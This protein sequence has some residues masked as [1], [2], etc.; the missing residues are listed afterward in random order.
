MDEIFEKRTGLCRGKGG[1]VHLFAPA[2]RFSC[3]GIVGSSLPVA[4]G[5]AYAARLEGTDALAVGVTGDGGTNTG[6]FH[7]T[8]NMAAIWRLPLVVLVENNQYAIS[9]PAT[10][11]IAGSGIAERAAAYGAWGMRV[12]GTDVEAVA[13]AF[14][15]A[16]DHARNG[17]GPALL[18]A[19]CFRFRGHYEG[20]TDHYRSD[21]HKERMLTQGDP[22]WITGRRL[23]DRGEA[24]DARLSEIDREVRA[25]IAAVLQ[26]AREAPEPGPDEAFTDVFA[27]T[28]A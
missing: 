3:T 6:Q 10:D 4:L 1:H 20:D 5:H 19:T 11:V 7:E 13:R 9:V 26:R 8:M 14:R 27:E 2:Q 15:Q 25:E 16:A 21:E 12:D 24:D 28:S 22:L 17:N 18:E 23:V